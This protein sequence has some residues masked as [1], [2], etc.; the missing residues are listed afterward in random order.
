MNQLKCVC[1]VE[2]LAKAHIVVF[3]YLFWGCI[4]S[5][6]TSDRKDLPLL[7]RFLLRV[8]K[9]SLENFQMES[10]GIFWAVIVPIMLIGDVFLNLVLLVFLPFPFNYLSVTFITLIVAILVLRIHLERFLNTRKAILGEGYF[11]WDLDKALQEYLLVLQKRKN[12]N[13]VEKHR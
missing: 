5:D 7:Y 8:P 9:L 3:E 6:N 10:E 2:P 12:S 13:G 1:V 11:H 4:V